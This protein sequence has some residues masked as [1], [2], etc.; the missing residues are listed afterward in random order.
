MGKTLEAVVEEIP[1]AD[2][3]GHARMGGSQVSL[4]HMEGLGPG[5]GLTRAE[6]RE[7]LFDALSGDL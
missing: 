6:F 5:G 3:G 4:E 7:Q 1:A 2:A